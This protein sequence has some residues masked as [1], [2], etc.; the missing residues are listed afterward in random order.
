[1]STESDDLDTFLN[2]YQKVRHLEQW[3]G[4]DLD[5][6]FH[7]RRHK[8]IWAIRRRTFRRFRR[9]AH[10]V[11]R[12]FA[13]D[14]G[15]GNCWMTRY[16]SSWGF[17]A[18]AVDV[19]ASAADG[20]GAA[21]VFLEQGAVFRRVRASMDRLPFRSGLV[22]LVAAN[23]SI[24]YAPD[25]MA[26][27]AEFRR[28]VAPGGIIAVLDT[29]C[30]DHPADGERMVRERAQ[31]FRRDFDLPEAV[32]RRS[33]Y[34]TFDG[35]RTLATSLDLRYQIVPVWPGLRRTGQALRARL[36]GQPIAEF[37]IIIFEK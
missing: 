10:H 11:P 36:A 30:Y 23:A 25:L 3:G 22:S 13:V 15:A 20:L 31:R 29:P 12:G 24:H 34:L 27:L 17:D 5:L 2:A 8:N 4:D 33:R 21:R 28:V 7:P 14:V 35:I 37:P 16:L 18:V 26:A 6:P 19:D 9:L 1:V 32:A